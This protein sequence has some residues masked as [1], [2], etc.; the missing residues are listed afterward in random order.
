MAMWAGLVLLGTSWLFPPWTVVIDSTREGTHR[1][2]QITASFAGFRC[3]LL[4]KE[5]W[6]DQRTF[7]I[8]VPLLLIINVGI[9]A[10]TAAA[11]VSL[12]ASKM[13]RV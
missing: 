2:H 7:Q 12:Y 4:P 8:D 5:I 11:I 6:S 13:K 1:I 10:T 3:V 9:A